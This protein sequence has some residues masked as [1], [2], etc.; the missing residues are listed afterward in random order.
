MN[1]KDNKHTRVVDRKLGTKDVNP[2][3]K[4]NYD[5]KNFK[6]T[7][8]PKN[9]KLPK[10]TKGEKHARF[11]FVMMDQYD[12]IPYWTFGPSYLAA[13]LEKN[14]Y[15]V[16]IFNGTVWHLNPK[17]LEKFLLE[18][19]AF[20][21]IGIGYLTNYVH[22]VIQYVES[23]RS[24]SPK[25]KIIL[26]GNGYSPLPAFYLDK[27][28][29]DYGVSGEAEN[30]LLNLVNA[31][32]TGMSPEEIPSV[33]FRDGEDIHVSTFREPVPFID[34]IPQPAYH[35]FPIES[36]VWYESRG[37]NN[38]V[39]AFN[40]LS[41]R[42]CPYRCNFCY[43]L[44]EGFRYRPFD[45]F[46]AEIR[47]LHDRHGILHFNMSDELFMTSK[48]HVLQFSNNIIDAFDKG[49]L[50]RNISWETTGRFNIVDQEVAYA[51][52]S[53]GCNRILYG[54]ES[55]DTKVLEL[56]NKKT[57]YEMIETGI[58]MTKRAG[59]EVQLPCMFGNIGETASS[60][61]KTV[62]ILKKHASTDKR[63][64]RPVTAYPGSPLYQ[65]ALDKGLLKNHNEFFEISKNPD[66]MTINFTEMSDE[67]YYK[68]MYEAN[69]E[70][71]D[72]Y[73]SHM[74]EVEKESF[75]KL[76]FDADDSSFSLVDHRQ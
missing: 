68:V 6:E 1:N 58:E 51:M 62:E 23:I 29:A 44:E 56:M 43:R 31:L 55:G 12:R 20:D 34:D 17:D 7:K 24:A 8:G 14:D 22:D 42:G 3:L 15:H 66:L 30:S 16:E 45:D 57:S 5:G 10:L 27:T 26:G 2:L 19:E 61:K 18:R 72:H 41:S 48:K 37:Y 32:S 4:I 59:I 13:V 11:L 64:L 33:T 25:S 38:G 73:H 35:L 63:L 67:T 53:A 60:V 74:A 49:L 21:Y 39:K 54:L 71:I 28:G 76:Y 52:S 50:P 46:V 9:Y 47:Y 40:I 36:Y 69:V 70:L 75:S 65:Y